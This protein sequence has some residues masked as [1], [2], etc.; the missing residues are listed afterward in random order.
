M[1]DY[2]VADALT[3]IENSAE[4]RASGTILAARITLDGR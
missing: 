1:S 2:F 4:R 3:A